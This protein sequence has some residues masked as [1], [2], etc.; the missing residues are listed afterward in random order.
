[1][2][3][4]KIG[5]AMSS[6]VFVHVRFESY[7]PPD[8][9]VSATFHPSDGSG[10]L[11]YDRHRTVSLCLQIALCRKQSRLGREAMQHTAKDVS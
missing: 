5:E 1:M 8:Q 10:S 3:N 11:A 7:R 6:K 9:I 4:G 2:E